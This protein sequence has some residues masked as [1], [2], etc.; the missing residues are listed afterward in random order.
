M[1]FTSYQFIL[2]V[3]LTSF[4]YYLPFFKRIQIIILLLASFVF[5]AYN[6]PVLLLLLIASFSTN[7]LISYLIYTNRSGNKK[8]YAVS[9]VIIN[10]SLLAAFKYS[11]LFWVTFYGNPANAKGIGAFI[12]NLPLPLAI[13][14][15]TFQGI[16]L[17][18]DAFR[19]KPEDEKM[20]YL[21]KNFTDHFIK[22]MF[23]ISFFPKLLQGPLEKTNSFLPQVK[24]KFFNDINSLN[25]FKYCVLGY[26]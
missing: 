23:F 10:L 5:Y 13:S 3:V 18:V 26:F 22:C 9:G 21:P 15:Y 4:L 14:F 16:S 1:L 19:T 25:V 6:N 7:A 11:K 17:V 2:L 24:P 20:A 8:I 12:I